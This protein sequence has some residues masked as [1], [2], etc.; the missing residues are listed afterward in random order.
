M[1]GLNNY[2][3]LNNF[4]QDGVKLETPGTSSNGKV[5]SWE[6]RSQVLEIKITS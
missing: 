5:A 6:A 2:E 4:S 3:N 1:R